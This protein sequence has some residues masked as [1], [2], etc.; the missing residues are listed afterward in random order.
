M[1][2]N[3]EQI[4]NLTIL[5]AVCIGTSVI[6]H[7]CDSR[8]NQQSK[9]IKI[10]RDTVIK[11]DTIPQYYPKP[12]EVEKVRTEYQWL[13]IAKIVHDTVG[14][15]QFVHD[16]VLVEVPIT[17][18]HYHGE[19]YDAWVS[20]YNPSLDSISVYQKEVLV[21][22]RVTVSKPPNKLS[23]DIRTGADYFS[24]LKDLW[25]YASANAEYNITN[26]RF[27]IGAR[28]GVYYDMQE[29]RPFGGGY[30]KLRI[31]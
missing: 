29:I 1:K 11:Y 17:S 4:Y 23:L 30:I 18:K 26:S 31:H 27:S 8:N 16:S 19:Q 10:E 21:T 7:R 9:V 2:L 3:K 25:P 14:F 15:T 12:V 20:G 22:E 13:P 5:I 28:C 6:T 24:G